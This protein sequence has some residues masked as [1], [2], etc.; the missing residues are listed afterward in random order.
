MMNTNRP[1][2][3]NKSVYDLCT[4]YPELKG[5]MA[6][7]GFTQITKKGMLG[8]IGRMMTI[9]KGAAMQHI[10]LEKVIQ[11]LKD[12]GFVVSGLDGKAAPA[13]AESPEQK[14]EAEAEEAEDQGVEERRALLKSYIKRL[15][16]GEDLETVRKEFV[17]NFSEVKASE[18]ATAEQELLAS[19]VPLQDVQRL[20]DVHSALFHGATQAEKIAAAEAAVA[21]EMKENQP[22][23]LKRQDGGDLKFKQ[24]AQISGHPLQVFDLENKAIEKQL[25]QMKGALG[26]GSHIREA[27]EKTREV[28]IHYAKKGDLIYPIL[29][30]RY[31]FSGPSDVM[32]SVDDEIRDEL[33]DLANEA[34]QDETA[35][36]SV[37]WRVRLSK[38]LGRAEEMIYKEENILY[39]LCAK[40]FSEAEWRQMAADMRDYENCLIGEV[41]VW[42]EAE[43]AKSESENAGEITFGSGHLRVDQLE[44]MLNTIPMELTFIDAEDYNRYFN[45]GEGPKLFKRPLMALDRKVYTCHPPKIEPMVR[46][47]IDSFKD[48][49]KN[50]VAV[51]NQRAG[52]PVYIRYLAVR[53]RKGQYVGTLECVEEMD[54][55]QKH[56]CEEEA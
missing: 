37:P 21:A 31:G 17:A 14:Q 36:Q 50:E 38:A 52:K 8:T 7:L 34:A 20:C 29:K 10:D 13:E 42:K 23:P 24:L 39:P 41:P 4:A 30:G 44:A 49:S 28:A 12:H 45:D 22:K 11:A 6:E 55:A 35:V 9:P 19:G 46:M 51:W 53:N 15:S 26:A 16:D 43:S 2:D 1:L 18:I 40:S 3:L 27:L 47:I 48:G 5:I 54:F 25:V 56:F 33:R 32:W